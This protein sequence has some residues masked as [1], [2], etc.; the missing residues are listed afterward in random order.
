MVGDV[1]G[2]LIRSVLAFAGPI[3][4][5][6]Q[7]SELRVTQE[8][9]DIFSRLEEIDRVRKP[10]SF[11]ARQAFYFLRLFPYW[12][13][14]KIASGPLSVQDLRPANDCKRPNLLGPPF[15]SIPDVIKAARDLVALKRFITAAPQEWKEQKIFLAEEEYA[16]TIEDEVAFQ[17]E[18]AALAK[19]FEKRMP[20]NFNPLNVAE[21]DSIFDEPEAGP[22]DLHRN[23]KKPDR[24][25]AGTFRLNRDLSGLGEKDFQ[26]EA[27]ALC[28]RYGLRGVRANRAIPQ[29]FEIGI[30]NHVLVIRIPNYMRV[31][32]ARDIPGDV[33][34]HLQARQEYASDLTPQGLEQA[35]S[36]ERDFDAWRVFAVCASVMSRRDATFGTPAVFKIIG[37]F[38]EMVT[39]IGGWLA[40]ESGDSE[41]YVAKHFLRDISTKYTAKQLASAL[42]DEAAC[43]RVRERI[44][45]K[46]RN[47][48]TGSATVEI[49]QFNARRSQQV[50]LLMDRL[51]TSGTAANCLLS[52]DQH[53]LNKQRGSFWNALKQCLAII[54]WKSESIPAQPPIFRKES[55]G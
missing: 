24:R 46:I 47:L 42:A 16:R 44:I 40:W 34:R 37:Q 54:K 3:R 8:V 22:D 10:G 14:T 4:S 38:S 27:S 52:V 18:W 39:R 9:R 51:R 55:K 13:L 35:I 32:L 45:S 17:E 31:D 11:D 20:A 21:M 43:G 23:P 2:K 5:L 25:L 33:V 53:F 36:R 19:K 49:R 29:W 28:H 15:S 7:S 48:N 30:E 41:S 50:S 6:E 26:Y 12:T 1:G